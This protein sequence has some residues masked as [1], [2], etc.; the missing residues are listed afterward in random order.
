ME[1][2]KTQISQT[3]AEVETVEP[4]IPET[5]AEEKLEN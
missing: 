3:T 5:T 4:Q 2:S 1:I